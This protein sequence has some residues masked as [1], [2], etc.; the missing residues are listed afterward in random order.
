MHDSSSTTYPMGASLSDILLSFVL[1]IYIVCDVCGL[2]SPSVEFSSVL[3]I[4]PIFTSS[5]QDLMLQGMQQKLQKPRT[6]SNNNTCHVESSHILQS[7][8][9]LL[10]FVNRLG[11][12]KNDATE[13]RCSIP[14]DTT[15]MLGPLKFSLRAF[16][17]HRGASV[18]FGHYM[19]STNCW[20]EKHSIAT[21]TKLR[22]L[23]LFI[24]K[25]SP[26]H[27]SYFVN[28]LTYAFWNRPRGWDH[29]HGAGTSSPSYQQQV[30]E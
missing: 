17:E 18:H 7:P 25:L 19:A 11:Y 15:V 4:T 6:R 5:V 3:F 21:T 14:M 1:E 20:K 2:R 9:Y 16:I 13:D 30:E 12:P 27:N 26:L 23:E 8:K 28:W 22:S 29:S 24:A 10:L